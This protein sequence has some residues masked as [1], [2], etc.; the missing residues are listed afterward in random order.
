MQVKNVN[1][2]VALLI[3]TSLA[4]CKKLVMVPPPTTQLSSENVFTNNNAAASVLTGIYTDF[5]N[6]SVVPSGNVSVNNITLLA[7]LCADELTLDGGTANNNGTL[8][9]F[10]QNAL[11]AGSPTN[12]PVTI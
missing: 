5:A 3:L 12:D 1:K 7:G 6:A 11:T 2:I 9:Q 10:Y 8:V 4:G